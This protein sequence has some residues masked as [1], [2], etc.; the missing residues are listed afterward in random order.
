MT[1]VLDDYSKNVP[2]AR[3]SEVLNTMATFV[4]KLEV[5]VNKS[6]VIDI[7]STLVEKS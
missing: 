3:E 4:N 7:L 6:L 1:T 2:Q 5:R